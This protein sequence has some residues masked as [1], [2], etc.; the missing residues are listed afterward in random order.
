MDRR[1]V[2]FMRR[3]GVGLVA[4]GVAAALMMTGC[5]SSK[6]NSSGGSTGGATGASSAASSGG[7]SGGS[8]GVILPDETSSPRYITYDKPLLAKAFS[9]AGIKADIQN[10]QGDKGKFAT[11]AD[12]MIQ[13]GVQVMIVDG[14]D[15]PSAAAVEQKAKAA[16][17]KTIDYD[18]LTLGGSSDYYVSFDNVQVGKLQGQG[19]VDCL[20]GKTTANIIELNGSPDDNNATLFKQGYDSVLQPKYASGWKKVGDQSVPGWDKD[21]AVTIFQQLFTAAGGKVDGVLAANDTLGNAAITILKQNGLK[22]PVTGQ[23]ASIQGLQNILAG[24]QCMTVFKDVKLEANAAAKLAIALIK[25][26]DA[27]AA[28]ATA[29]SHDPTGKRDVPSVLLTPVSI[30]IKNIKTVTDT[31]EVSTADVC[32]GYTAQCK[33]A[34][35]TT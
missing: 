3:T 13:E 24:E 35:I 32:K 26:Q 25:G 28:G 12:S 30:T 21:K 4:V 31:G 11:I 14:L 34:G 9:D 23:D 27:K 20:T 16:G 1:G 5:S 33:T 18:R 7:K 15:S 10:A 29:S 8:V 19:L 6:K 17:I 2:V 22:I